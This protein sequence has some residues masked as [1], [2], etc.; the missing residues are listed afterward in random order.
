MINISYAPE[1]V[2][3][4]VLLAERTGTP[5]DRCAFRRERDRLY[6]IADI[7]QREAGFRSLH[8]QWFTRRGLHL[9]V[10]QIV[11][12]RAD[13]AARVTEGRVLRALTRGEEGADL[14]DRVRPGSAGLKPLLVLRLRPATLLAPDTLSALL[15]HE[16]MHVGDMLDPSF[17]YERALPASDDGPSADNIVRDRYRVLWD[18]TIDGRLVRAGL[19]SDAVRAARWREFSATFSMLGSRCQHVFDEWFDRIPPEHRTLLAFALAPN[20]SVST[21]SADARRCPLCR[22]PVASLDPH[23]E[24]LSADRR[25][26]IEADYP[27]WS[28]DQG[29]CPQCLDLYEAHHEDNVAR[30]G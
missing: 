29:L 10:E 25:E 15:H 26:A 3:E 4:A 24:R 8:R 17:G 13:M 5:E 28:I 27:A 30:R 14:I 9:I 12:G 23:P 2:E 22:F 21:K 1:L 18:V 6:E 7:D 20:G 19:A 11:A 16:L